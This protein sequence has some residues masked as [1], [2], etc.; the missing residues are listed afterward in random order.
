MIKQKTITKFINRLTEI[1]QSGLTRNAYA[2]IHNFHP[3]YFSITFTKIYNSYKDGEID[4]ETYNN[5]VDLMT[6]IDSKYGH[7]KVDNICNCKEVL[8]NE[9]KAQVTLDCV[10][11]CEADDDRNTIEFERDND[12]KI[13]YYKF[14]VLRRDKEPLVGKLSRDEANT[15]HRLYS[16]Y[17]MSITQ[18]EVSRYFPEWSLIDFKRILR[19]FNITK[20]SA[21]FAPHVIEENSPEK[22]LEMQLRE[23]E[24]DFLRKLE[25]ERIKN[26]EKLLTKYALENAELKE[27]LKEGKSLLS[28]L[29]IDNVAKLEF[30]QDIPDGNPSLIIWLSDMHIGA[31]V[32]QQSIYDNSYDENTVLTRLAKILIRVTTEA[33][34]FNSFSK[35]IVC[36]L[37]DSLDGMD[38]QTTRRD[39]YLPQNMTNKEQVHT[40]I[41]CMTRFFNALADYTSDLEYYCVGEANH[42]GDFGYVA[43]LALSEILKAKGVKSTIFDKFIG[44]FTTNNT[45]FVLCHGKDNK[46]M[47]KNLPLTLDVK[48]ENYINEY[49][50]TKKIT[51]NVVFVKGDLHQ[52]AVTYGRRFTYKSVASLFGSS[53]WIHK[54]FGNTP[55]ACDYSIIDSCE[56]ILDG[57][58]MLQ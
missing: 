58:I 32:S 36:N 29:K 18:R 35:I 12:G 7:Y 8:P 13:K 22:L 38:R 5:V 48:T 28:D 54:N 41:N 1:I 16:Y 26:N 10:S 17:G 34:K 27:E 15:I 23:K 44:E 56:H 53:E 6:V 19:V 51:G 43:N 20:A 46:D 11:D 2:S 31:N 4:T 47:F 3:S 52:S 50:D 40:F 21:P 39:H 45:T 30:K 24:N 49:L 57:R 14:K 33:N 42:D 9:T 55:A 37:G 25:T